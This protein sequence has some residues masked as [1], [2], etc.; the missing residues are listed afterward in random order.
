MRID[1][2]LSSGVNCLQDISAWIM[3]GTYGSVNVMTTPA[4]NAIP[5][6]IYIRDVNSYK[7]DGMTA[8]VLRAA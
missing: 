3:I 2:S 6:P 4:F 1:V 8:H 7:I 5:S